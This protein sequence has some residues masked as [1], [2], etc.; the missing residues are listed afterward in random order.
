MGA[1]K[2]VSGWIAVWRE[3]IERTQFLVNTFIQIRFKSDSTLHVNLICMLPS[4][5]IHLASLTLS[6]AAAHNNTKSKQNILICFIVNQTNSLILVFAL[7][8]HSKSHLYHG[9]KIVIQ[10]CLIVKTKLRPHLSASCSQQMSCSLQFYFHFVFVG[11]CC[12][13]HINIGGSWVQ[14]FS[15]V[16]FFLS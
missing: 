13:D 3:Y 14:Y 7:K 5:S 12:A 15:I 16:V 6:S 10:Q 1:C 8:K 11:I 2:Q 4:E 9:V